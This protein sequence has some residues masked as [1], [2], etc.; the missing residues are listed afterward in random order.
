[1]RFGRTNIIFRKSEEHIAF[2]RNGAAAQ[3][4]LHTE[5]AFARHLQGVSRER[6]ANFN[7]L[8]ADPTVSDLDE[9]KGR[10]RV[11]ADADFEKPVTVYHTSGDDVPFVP[12][13]TLHLAFSKGVSADDISAFARYAIPNPSPV[14]TAGFVVVS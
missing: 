12:E 8:R 1:M 13:G 6:I 5:E 9:A 10:A 11:V 2:R 3:G 14:A 4:K 7:V